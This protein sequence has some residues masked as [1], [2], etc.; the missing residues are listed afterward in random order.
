MHELDQLD[1]Q[2]T[3]FAQRKVRVVA[4]SVDERAEAAQTQQ[5][6]PHLMIVSDPAGQMVAAFQSNHPGQGPG[7]VDVAAP[8]TFLIDDA[9]MIRYFFRP[10]RFLVRQ[11]PEELLAAVD[12][13][14]PAP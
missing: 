12:Q 5:R 13:H 9:G 3:A 14:L 11:S 7:G 4:V 8:T 6:F 2:H 1:Q 10:D